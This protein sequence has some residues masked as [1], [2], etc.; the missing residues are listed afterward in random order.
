[1]ADRPS[2]WIFLAAAF[3]IAL[4]AFAIAQVMEGA[5]M[6][7][8]LAGSLL[9]CCFAQKRWGSSIHG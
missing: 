3:V 8:A 1:M 7:V 4:T 5:G 6:F 2:I 9:W